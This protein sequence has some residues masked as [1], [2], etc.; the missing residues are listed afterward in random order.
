MN[1]IN[2]NTKDDVEPREQQ[3]S[4]T[5]TVAVGRNVSD[6]KDGDIKP[7]MLCWHPHGIFVLGG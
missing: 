7:T 5:N 3:D 1:L 4:N 6:D 2:K